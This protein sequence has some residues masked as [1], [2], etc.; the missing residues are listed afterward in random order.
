MGGIRPDR[1]SGERRSRP[2]AAGTL[3]KGRQNGPRSNPLPFRLSGGLRSREG[4][5]S[6]GSRDRIPGG[7]A[8]LPGRGSRQR[9]FWESWLL[10]SWLLGSWLLGSWLQKRRARAIRRVICFDAVWAAAGPEARRRLPAELPSDPV[11][12]GIH[13]SPAITSGVLIQDSVL[14]ARPSGGLYPFACQCQPWIGRHPSE[15]RAI[16]MNIQPTCEAGSKSG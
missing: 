8:C 6:T 7:L 5:M 15:Q 14:K 3:G 1:L 9:I 4:R 12:A 16:W 10:E 11:Q 13:Q 2:S